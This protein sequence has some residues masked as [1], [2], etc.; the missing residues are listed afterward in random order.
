MDPMADQR[1][2]WNI[3][4]KCNCYRETMTDGKIPITH[5][6]SGWRTA[7]DSVCSFLAKKIMFPGLLVCHT[8]CYHFKT[9]R[10]CTKITAGTLAGR[11]VQI[12]A[13]P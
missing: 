3:I 10:V 6:N 11:L 4:L 7:L 12:S 8:Y 1:E 13:T 2:R 9:I 5:T